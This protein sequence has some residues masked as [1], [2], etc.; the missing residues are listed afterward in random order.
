MKHNRVIR[1]P[2]LAAFLR[3]MPP[4]NGKPTVVRISASEA[5]LPQRRPSSGVPR[6][7]VGISLQGLNAQSEIVWLYEGHVI[8][9]LPDSPG[10]EADRSIHEGI[11]TLKN[12]VHHHLS[13]LGYDVRE[14]DYALPANLQPLNARFECARWLKVNE[15][16]WMVQA[17]PVETVERRLAGDLPCQP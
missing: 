15:R 6:R 9:W 14:G 17:A 8:V 7:Q 12:I 2:S 3:E 16:N 1:V 5:T 13:A 10:F 11:I 4:V